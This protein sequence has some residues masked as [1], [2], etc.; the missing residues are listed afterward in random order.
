MYHKGYNFSL[1]YTFEWIFLIYHGW[2]VESVRSP[3]ILKIYM[4]NWI[5]VTCFVTEGT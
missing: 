4:G 2:P 5:V 3:L 1:S